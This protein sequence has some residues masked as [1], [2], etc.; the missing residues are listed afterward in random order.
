LS[1]PK[2]WYIKKGIF[3][4]E[5]VH[6]IS[7]GA[8]VQSSTM[9]LMAA[10]GEITPMPK[11]AIFADTQAEP[12]SVYRWLEWLEKQLPFAVHRVT[13]G[14]L[15]ESILKLNRRKDGKG[16]WIYSGIPAFTVGKDGSEGMIPRQCTTRFKVE[17]LDKEAKR[18]AMIK[19]GEK[20][21]RV[22]TWKGISLD[23]VHRMKPPRNR[24]QA[25]RYP[26]V[27]LRMRRGDCLEWMKKHG[28]PKPPRSACVYCPFHSD[29]EWR[30]LRDEEPEAFAEAVRVDKEFRKLKTISGFKSVP[31]MHVSRVPLDQV[32]FSTDEDHG[33]QVMFGNECEGMC[34]V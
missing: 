31:Y 30:R 1:R 2:N 7:L 21:I 10:H 17:V 14:S 32:D 20:A 5:P 27:D 33:Q 26:L 19:R 11:C 13:R 24:W 9:A 6:I 23:E 3:V 8:G 22:I 15:T 28:Y 29:T 25:F 34:G 16:F 18:I 12:Q 4:S